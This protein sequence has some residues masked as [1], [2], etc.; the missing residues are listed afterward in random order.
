MHDLKA[1]RDNPA[2]YDAGWARRG[3]EPQTP[4]ILEIDARLRAAKSKRMDAEAIRNSASKAIGA[5]KAQKN[6]E[7]AS[8]LM[9]EVAAA[10]ATMEQLRKK[11]SMPSSTLCQICPTHRYPK[12]R[13]KQVMWKKSGGA[14]CAILPLRP[15]ITSH[16]VK[17]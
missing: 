15:R 5:A 4:A 14:P 12:A 10:K 2:H 8:R 16:L 13:M 6:E 11:N 17:G 1:L 7:Q 9:D 3:M